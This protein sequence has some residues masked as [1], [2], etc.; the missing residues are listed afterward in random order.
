M[1]EEVR[2]KVHLGPRGS[3][4]VDSMGEHGRLRF[5]CISCRLGHPCRQ[6]VSQS[7]SRGLR[8]PGPTPW[9]PNRS[10]GLYHPRLH[11]PPPPPRW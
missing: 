8:E 2:D 11:P 1:A 9:G 10:P 4:S 5:V 3:A 7:A 6:H